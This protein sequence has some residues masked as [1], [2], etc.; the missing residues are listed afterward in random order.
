MLISISNA[1]KPQTEEFGLIVFE[2]TKIVVALILIYFLN[3]GIEG[4]IITTFLASLS[5][6]ILLIIRTK[7]KLRG[8]FNKK[9]VKKW[10]KL[11]WVPTYPNIS[12]L[13]SSIDVTVFIIV[14]GSVTGLAYWAAAR[15][16]SRIVIHSAKIG[17]AVYPKLLG[18]GKKEYLQENLVLV[19]FLLFRLHK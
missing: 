11:F 3:M 1:Y 18:G 4:V 15:A 16:I 10:F 6:V 12:S 5:S 13:L 2:I 7:E 17:K 9:Y 8:N 14:T 19:F